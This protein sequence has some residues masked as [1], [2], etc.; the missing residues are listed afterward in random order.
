VHTYYAD[1]SFE[2]TRSS[3][4]RGF[5]WS[6]QSQGSEVTDCLQYV[7][8]NILP[9][10]AYRPGVRL[11]PFAPNLVLVGQAYWM[12]DP[13]DAFPA[14]AEGTFASLPPG[15]SVPIQTDEGRML[16]SKMRVTPLKEEELRPPTALL[17]Q[18]QDY[19][20]VFQGTSHLFPVQDFAHETAASTA[21]TS[22]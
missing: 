7:N 6:L 2:F 14:D 1:G 4:S 9:P 16:V 5:V 19:V 3:E 11:R 22:G 12:M 15:E 8:V 21:A 20:E 10:A 13:P 18:I 17:A